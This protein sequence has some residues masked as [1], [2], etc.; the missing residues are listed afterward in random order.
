MTTGQVR[1][2]T[3][4]EITTAEGLHL[5]PDEPA[6]LR[7]GRGGRMFDHGSKIFLTQ[8]DRWSKNT[9]VEGLHLGPDE[10]AEQRRAVCVFD[11]W[12]RRIFDHRSN[13]V[14]DHW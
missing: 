7:T 2:L 3:T 8:I 4:G 12:S 5:G 6:D 13:N 1:Y 14:F 10:P 9:A 11:H